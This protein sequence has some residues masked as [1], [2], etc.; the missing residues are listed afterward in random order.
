MRLQAAKYFI[1]PCFQVYILGRNCTYPIL[2]NC[3]SSQINNQKPP[4]EFQNMMMTTNP[5]QQTCLMLPRNVHCPSYRMESN[6]NG[7]S[8]K[9]QKI[10]NYRYK[11]PLQVLK[12]IKSLCSVNA[13]IRKMEQGRGR[14][15]QVHHER[16]LSLL[17]K[18]SF[19][20]PFQN[21]YRGTQL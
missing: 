5:I 17:K 11:R 1:G 20:H 14:R 15:D 9:I 6:L 21:S 7:L 18:V 2:S 10:I 4:S 3:A 8:I 13:E 12:S 19:S 16:H